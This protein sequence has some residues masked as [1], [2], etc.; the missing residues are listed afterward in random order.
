MS[1]ILFYSLLS[2]AFLGC[3]DTSKQ[4]VS[5]QSACINDSIDYYSCR[6]F[7]IVL[8][9]EKILVDYEGKYFIYNEEINNDIKVDD[10]CVINSIHYSEFDDKII[11]YNDY[12][13]GG[14][15]YNE[16][17][18]MN[19]STGEIYW[20]YSFPFGN[21]NSFTITN[22]EIILPG[23]W[24]VGKISL[25]DGS[26][27]WKKDVYSKYEISRID[28]YNIENN[29]IKIIG[30]RYKYPIGWEQVKI[31]LDLKTGEEK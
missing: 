21:I 22:D 20:V 7:E 26:L 2:F 11:L 29:I 12:D 15:G 6:L 18:K 14:E 19:S 27:I 28:N 25:I 9:K 1:R 30:L 13:C 31:S 16:I 17:I 10:G 24:A 4:I 23:S 8:D 3:D 5:K